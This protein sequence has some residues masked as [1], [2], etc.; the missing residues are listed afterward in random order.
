MRL[1]VPYFAFLP[2]ARRGGAR[3]GQARA[4]AGALDE[5]STGRRRPA[6]SQTLEAFAAYDQLTAQCIGGLP[7]MQRHQARLILKSLFVLSLDGH[8][9]T[10]RELC[11]ALLLPEE[12][13]AESASRQVEEML[14]RFASAS[15][16]GGLRETAEAGGQLRYRF[17]I[18]VLDAASA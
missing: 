10:A 8:G 14:A 4:L 7:V 2:F 5:C 11:A 18:G 15:T 13:S 1:Y 9:A 3:R 16:S 12:L 6:Q 17:R